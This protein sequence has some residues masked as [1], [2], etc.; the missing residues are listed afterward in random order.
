MT[1]R[2]PWSARGHVLAGL[3]TLAVLLG[4]FGTWAVMTN[5]AGAIIASGQVEV[6]QNRQIVQHPDGGVVAE[7]AIAEGEVAEAGQ[8]LIRLDGTLLR[9][10]L[11]IAESRLN[12]V[13]A[14]RGRLAAERDG[15]DSI[16][17]AAE[18]LAAA[19]AD[20]DVAELV[21]G[22]ETLFHVRRET[23][24]QQVAQ[25][26]RRQ[27][28]IRTQI[29]GIEAQLVALEAQVALIG[30]EL[31]GQQTLLDRGLAQAARVLGLQREQ[32][33]LEGT[34]GQLIAD[35]AQAEERITEISLQIIGLDAQR[36][37]DAQTQLRDLGVQELELRERRA[38]VQ[39]RLERLDIR[40][41]V[42]GV[43]YGLQVTTPRAV[44]RPA[45]P[46]LYLVPQDRPLIIA[47]R[48]DP[49]DIDHV[50]L[51]QEATLTFA[52]FGTR[53]MPE[54]TGRVTLLSADAFVDE[55]TQQRYY[56]AELMLLPAAIAALGERQLLPGMPVEAFMRTR[57]RTPLDYLT[58]PMTDYFA[59]AFRES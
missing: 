41:P 42:S 26:E 51:G 39:E 38:A 37:E 15:A 1:E 31:E 55:R 28:Q 52:T 45:E 54:L 22:Q 49:G 13:L 27:L 19:A 4:G 5:I 57:D 33:R 3:L 18:L 46:A 16:I 32:A 8:I 44:L 47:A 23:V 58:R 48:I 50:Y 20:P 43:V 14:R 12:E 24:M 21:D 30:E 2:M 11:A 7:V 29:E 59:R 17:F 40:A 6:E 35:R 34:R 36:R 9:S 25:L 10:E 56:R 53:D